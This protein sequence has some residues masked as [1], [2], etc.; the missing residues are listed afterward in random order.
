MKKAKTKYPEEIERLLKEEMEYRDGN[1][2]WTVPGG[3]RRLDKPAG[4]TEGKGR[5]WRT[6][7]LRAEDRTYKVLEHRAIFWLHHGYWPKEIDHIDRNPLNNRVENLREV[8]R[9]ENLRN[10]PAHKDSATGIKN[11]YWN[12]GRKKYVVQIRVGSMRKTVGY[13]KDIEFVELLAH[14]ARDKYHGEYAYQYL[15]SFSKASE[16]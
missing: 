1:M 6:L 14:E 15:P 8:S 12:K 16:E 13:S 10:I 5:N 11:V 9:S 4:G 2:Y 7:I 3:R